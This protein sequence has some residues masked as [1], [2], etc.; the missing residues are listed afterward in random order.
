MWKLKSYV[1]FQPWVYVDNAFSASE[2]S[3]I[4]KYKDEMK[5]EEATVGASDVTINKG[6]RES[7]VRWLTDY[8]KTRW[9]YEKLTIII[10]NI[11][12][13]YFGIDLDHIQ[14]LQLTEYDGSKKGHYGQHTDSSYESSASQNRKLSFFIAVK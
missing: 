10:E 1:P 13:Q 8:E 2:I 9:L 14:T 5:T 11:N 7:N 4:L 12:N 6:I 3:T